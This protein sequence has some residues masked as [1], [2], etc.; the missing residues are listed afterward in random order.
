MHRSK[1]VSALIVL[2][3]TS[4]AFS[5]AI[6]QSPFVLAECA[7]PEIVVCDNANQ[8]SLE[9]NEEQ[10]AANFVA[11]N[12]AHQILDYIVDNYGAPKTFR[13]S[14]GARFQD[15]DGSA[16]SCRYGYEIEGVSARS[17]HYIAHHSTALDIVIE[18]VPHEIIRDAKA[19]S[20]AFGA[21]YAEY[22]FDTGH[23]H[24]QTRRGWEIR[25]AG[26]DEAADLIKGEPS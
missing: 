17:Q 26:S 14:G 12:G 11:C 2:L 24:F 22:R 20:E 8:Y 13:I 16:Y 21:G 23:W 10:Y 5:P 19:A 15:A 7:H 25:L 4:A 18:G 9:I 3:I 6:S 1:A